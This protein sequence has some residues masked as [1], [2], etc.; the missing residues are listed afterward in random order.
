MTVPH[1]ARR[2]AAA[3]AALAMTLAFAGLLAGCGSSAAEQED[4]PAAMLEPFEGFPP[5][6]VQQMREYP[7]AVRTARRWTAGATIRVAFRGGTADAQRSIEQAAAEWT[8]HANI[9]LDF[10]YDSSAHSFRSWAPTDT[11]RAAEIRIA[12]DPSGYW[13]CVGTDSVSDACAAAGQPSMNLAHLDDTRTFPRNW[14][15]L[16]LHEFGHA[17]GLDHEHLNPQGGCESEF[18]WRDEA[19]YQQT[20][21]RYHHFVSDREGRRPGLYTVLGGPPNG[22]PRDVV[23]HNL[24]QLADSRA[25]PKTP[26]DRDSIMKYEFPARQLVRGEASACYARRSDTL[27]SGDRSGIAAAYPR[28]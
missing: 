4:G 3:G 25:F 5:E 7:I 14:A 24:R 8:L 2:F 6:R 27:S 9:G 23:D 20:R 10:G 19:G 17:L 28:K 11:R 26:F 13:S 22:W 1:D 18:L 15:S 12:F 16:V 21:D